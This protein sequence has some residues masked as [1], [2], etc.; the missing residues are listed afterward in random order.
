MFPAKQAGKTAAGMLAGTNERPNMGHSKQ[1]RMCSDA[2]GICRFETNRVL[3]SSSRHSDP[4]NCCRR[5]RRRPPQTWPAGR[6]PG[7]CCWVQ[8]HLELLPSSSP[9][10]QTG[11]W[12]ALHPSESH[13]TMAAPGW[14]TRPAGERSRSLNRQVE[15]RK[16]QER[17][18]TMPPQQSSSRLGQTAVHLQRA[19][20]SMIVE[21][22]RVRHP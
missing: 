14:P 19:W 8:E 3:T 5:H 6:R 15:E 12:L 21:E 13:N 11:C 10:G 20:S 17:C 18:K 4:A 16:S 1:K 7:R 9:P 22:I 2:S